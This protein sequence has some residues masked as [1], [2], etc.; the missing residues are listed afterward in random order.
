M[1]GTK[2]TLFLHQIQFISTPNLI[3][4]RQIHQESHRVA[5]AHRTIIEIATSRYFHGTKLLLTIDTKITAHL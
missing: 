5:T 1:L 3:S 4:Q 2:F